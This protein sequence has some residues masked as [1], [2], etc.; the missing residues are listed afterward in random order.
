[1]NIIQRVV[2]KILEKIIKSIL[3]LIYRINFKKI[4]SQKIDVS[5]Q[6]IKFSIIIPT[7]NSN[8]D[9]LIK[10]LDSVIKQTYQNWELCIS[11]DASNNQKTL[12]ILKKYSKNKKIKTFPLT[13]I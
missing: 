8:P 2:Q 6:K 4:S 11:D 1:M 12:K 3:N 9:Y 10:C 13:Q 7:Y 5:N